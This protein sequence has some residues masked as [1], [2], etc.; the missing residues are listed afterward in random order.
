MPAKFTAEE[1][2]RVTAEL[3]SAGYELFTT[4]GLRKTSLE[5]L[6]GR[7]G[8]AKSSFY[9]FF[10][11]KEQL[12]LELML[13]QAPQVAERALGD[14]QQVGDA[15]TGLVRIL[16]GSRETTANDPLYRRLLTH[17]DELEAVRRRV[18]ADEA[19]RVRPHLLQPVLDFITRWQ[20]C[21]QLVDADPELVFGVIR[22]AGLIAAHREEF[23]E[24][25]EAVAQLLTDVVATG[26]TTAHHENAAHRE[27]TAHH[28]DAE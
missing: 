3:L 16:T 22:A 1:R 11:S 15:R 9:A 4:Q 13:R 10:D 18:G 12:Y 5:E 24:H 7:A 21:G 2:E 25:Y 23:G 26:L 8:I 27:D 19:E 14:L 28:E 20:R 6:A 17:P